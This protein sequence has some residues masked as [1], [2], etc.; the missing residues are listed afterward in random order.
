MVTNT[1]E[2]ASICDEF[3]NHPYVTI[4]IEFLRE[5]TF[6][7]IL[8]LI[9]MASSNEAVIIDPMEK[10]LSLEPFFKLMVNK[11]VVKVFHGARQDIEIIYHQGDLIPTPLFDTQIAAM[12][13]GYGDSIAYNQ[14][15]SKITNIEI[16]KSS[17]ITDWFQRPLSQKQLD[18]ALADVTYLRQIYESLKDDLEKNQRE[19]WIEEEIAILKSP[20]TYDLPIEQAWTRLKMRVHNPL[21]FAI[22]KQVAA[23]REREARQRNIPR[24]QVIPDKA[25]YEIAQKHP[26]NKNDLTRLR[27]VSKWVEQSQRSCPDSLD[28]L[29]KAIIDAEEICH[30]KGLEFRLPSRPTGRK[31]AETELLRLLLKIVSEASGVASKLI[32]TMD[33]LE[34]IAEK[35]DANVAAL[36][37]W[38]YEIFGKSALELKRGEISIG[39]E[40]QK[41]KIM[42]LG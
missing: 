9:Q 12:V 6:W 22:M 1:D 5:T 29:L 41:I 38:R 40:D 4:D 13:C 35:E 14:L 17:R 3:S 21:D 20:K 31:G 11:R 25:I 39:F 19:D 18:Y 30:G 28:R 37:G 15:V 10:R 34:K 26:Q 27:A 24:R 32:A 36:S 2:L 42:K 8:C 7:P 23:W 33:D 16:D